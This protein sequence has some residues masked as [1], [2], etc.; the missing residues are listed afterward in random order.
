MVYYCCEGSL[1]DAADMKETEGSV[2]Y[3]EDVQCC[4]LLLLHIISSRG[5]RAVPVSPV[6]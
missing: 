4:P 6:T 2:C 1:E 5:S 3:E